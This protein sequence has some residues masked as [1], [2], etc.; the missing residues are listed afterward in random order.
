MVKKIFL[1]PALFLLT[2][3][4]SCSTFMTMKSHYQDIDQSVALRDYN[5]ALTQL[6]T[7]KE[8]HYSAKDRV[9]FYLEEGMLLRYAG[10]WEASNEAL[11]KAEVAIEELFTESISKSIASGVLNDN[12]LDYSGED[13]EDIYINI[14]K[15]LNYIQ[16]KEFESALVEVRR[17]NEKL[18]YLE[19]KYR[20][21][22]DEYNTEG[23]G[24]L[25]YGDLRFHNDA[26]ARYLGILC[27]RMEGSYNSARI[28]RDKL[29]EAYSLQSSIY[30]FLQPV[31]LPS[32]T[33]KKDKAYLNLMSFAG[34]APEKEAQTLF[35]ATEPNYVVVM[36]AQGN[37]SFDPSVLGFAQL[38]VP[39][40]DGGFNMKMEFP[41]LS[42][43]PTEI[44]RV[45]VYVDGEYVQEL[46]L[47]EDIDSVAEE[48][49]QLKQSWIV[50][51]SIIRSVLKTITKEKGKEAMR[52]NLDG[53]LGFLAGLAT[54]IA[55][56]ATE[57]ADLRISRY[58]P[59]KAYG[60]EIEIDPGVYN[61]SLI[62]Y[63]DYGTELFRDDY[64]DTVVSLRGLNLI[65]SHLLVE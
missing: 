2:G 50:G 29:E 20:G 40:V 64:P 28:E 46:E 56:Y 44:S 14:F 9:L 18:N 59:S 26:L 48:T 3:L 37:S 42:E 58:F 11:T 39:G 35:L 43:R 54:D 62:Y 24:V 51:K 17:V 19:D 25:P 6:R 5:T 31:F 63:D 47:I 27:Y 21:L 55:V 15:A 33:F 61:I 52:E 49:F 23:D 45:S 32:N 1:I 60:T 36:G 41:Y 38:Y 53:G 65:E 10:E 30:D 7:V 57:N 34:L 12:A 8:S 22:I 16:L 4:T 13:Y